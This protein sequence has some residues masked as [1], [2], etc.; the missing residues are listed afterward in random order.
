MGVI[1]LSFNSRYRA[2]NA[3]EGD[4]SPSGQNPDRTDNLLARET[5][6]KW[7]CVSNR[8]FSTPVSPIA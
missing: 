8:R 3:C 7:F 2:A 6:V 5:F 4:V 1:R